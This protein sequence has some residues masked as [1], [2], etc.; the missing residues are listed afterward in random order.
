MCLK[1]VGV[2]LPVM[3]GTRPWVMLCV[4]LDG[5]RTHRLAMR[6]ATMPGRPPLTAEERALLQLDRRARGEHRPRRLTLGRVD[7]TPYFLHAACLPG[8]LPIPHGELGGHLA[9]EVW[10]ELYDPMFP[11]APLFH[12]RG[13]DPVPHPFHY[14][15]WVAHRHWTPCSLYPH[16]LQQDETPCGC[17]VRLRLSFLP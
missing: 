14:V 17:G 6:R 1:A 11:Y 2:E 12:L 5:V 3:T 7:R 8:G 10:V 13:S 15:R 9:L 4:Y 16:R